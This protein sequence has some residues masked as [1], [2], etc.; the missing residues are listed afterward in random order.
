M[1]KHDQPSFTPA[2][3]AMAELQGY[4]DAIRDGCSGYD[5][6]WRCRDCAGR[7][8][9]A[10]RKHHDE[11]LAL[12]AELRTPSESTTISFGACARQGL[13]ATPLSCDREG[14]CLQAQTPPSAELSMTCKARGVPCETPGACGTDGCCHH[15][16]EAVHA[17]S[18]VAVIDPWVMDLVRKHG[19]TMT[20]A[21]IVKTF[22]PKRR[23]SASSATLATSEREAKLRDFILGIAD[24]MLAC[25]SP[26]SPA[27]SKLMRAEGERIYEFVAKLSPHS[28]SDRTVV[29]K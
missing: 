18:E 8:A 10:P 23:L 1:R 5:S 14:K 26:L 13:C 20:N 21:E 9:C 17:P 7:P 3:R 28:S 6:D 4:A 15:S 29:P 27:A 2:E 16:G 12:V 24:G 25:D 19:N 22:L 11:L